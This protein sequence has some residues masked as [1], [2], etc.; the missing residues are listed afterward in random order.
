MAQRVSLARGLYT[1]PPLLL[2][3]EPFS[4]VDALTRNSLQQL[5]AS[6]AKRHHVTVVLVTHDV[7]E[8]VYLS[9]RVFVLG[10]IPSAIIAEVS[11]PSDKPRN[12][13]DEALFNYK[14]I[15][16]EHLE[17]VSQFNSTDHYLETKHA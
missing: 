7:D 4:A 13:T 16:L 11:I 9:D 15:I 8:A 12:R 6:V 3:D 1:K 5:L 14:K 2:L 17:T 10:G